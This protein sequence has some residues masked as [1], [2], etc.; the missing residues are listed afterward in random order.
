MIGKKGPFVHVS[1]MIANLL[2]KVRPFHLIRE[3][4]LL[5]VLI[6]LSHRV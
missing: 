2:S 3:V 5:L 1:S 4:S 6:S